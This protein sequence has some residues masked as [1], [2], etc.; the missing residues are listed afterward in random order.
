M[1]LYKWKSEDIPAR[2]ASLWTG[3][4][5]MPSFDDLR[6]Q[7]KMFYFENKKKNDQNVPYEYE[8]FHYWFNNTKRQF[9]PV[10]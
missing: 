10:F 3:F 5:I 8:P 7:N 2:L 9:P 4:K 1:K 6:Q